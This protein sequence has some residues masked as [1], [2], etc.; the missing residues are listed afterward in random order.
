MSDQ[1]I[2]SPGWSHYIISAPLSPKALTVV[3]RQI[4]TLKGQDATL[5]PLHPSA[6]TLA[7]L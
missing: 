3:T 7:I 1:L 4:K 6:L 5:R 2:L